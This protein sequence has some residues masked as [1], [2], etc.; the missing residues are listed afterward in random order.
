LRELGIVHYRAGNINLAAR[1]LN[2][3]LHQEPQAKDA[4]MI[5]VGMEKALNRWAS[6]N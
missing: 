1:Y 5:K 3:Y 6:Q 4:D 2:D